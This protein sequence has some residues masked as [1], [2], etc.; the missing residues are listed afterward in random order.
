MKLTQEIS[1]IELPL[2]VKYAITNK[3][4][5]LNG[6]GGISYLFLNN[7]TIYAETDNGF[8]YKIGE[9]SRMFD[10]TFGINLGL[11]IDYKITKRL[12]FNIEPMLKYNLKTSDNDVT[13][14]ISISVLSGFQI[15]IGAQ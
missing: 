3:K 12:K 7:N 9:T 11:E 6:I 8:K 10:R 2:E 4:I 13:N 5:S 14:P 1:Y 15:I